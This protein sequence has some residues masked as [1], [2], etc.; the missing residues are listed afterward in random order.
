[1]EPPPSLEIFK[2]HSP[3]PASSYS[4]AGGH[5]SQFKLTEKDEEKGMCPIPYCDR[6]FKD[7]KA[8]MLTHQNKY[9]EKCPIATCNYHVEGFTRK[10]DKIR[11]ALTHYK[12]TMVCS[13]CPGSGSASDKSF[14]RTDV[15]KHHLAFVHGVAL[16]TRGKNAMSRKSR[17]AGQNTAAGSCSICSVTFANAQEFYEHLDG[18]VFRIV[19][20]M[21][22]LEDV[23]HQY[24]S[25]VADEQQVLNT[26]NG[27][28]PPL[29][30][31]YEFKVPMPLSDGDG[32]AYNT[33]PNVETMK[34]AKALYGATRDERGLSQLDDIYSLDG[35]HSPQPRSTSQNAQGINQ[36]G[37]GRVLSDVQQTYSLEDMSH[38]TPLFVSKVQEVMDNS[39]LLGLTTS[40]DPYATDSDASTELS[41]T[42]AST[43]EEDYLSKPGL[44]RRSRSRRIMTKSLGIYFR[45]TPVFRLDSL[46]ERPS[47]YQEMDTDQRSN[48]SKCSSNTLGG[49]R[50]VK[51][52][53]SSPQK[54]K[55]KKDDDQ[56]GDEEGDDQKRKKRKGIE[57]M[58]IVDRAQARPQFMACPYFKRNPRKYRHQ[59][60]CPGPGWV[61]VHRL[62]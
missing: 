51:G 50:T 35:S 27:H 9:P 62:K 32:K 17:S 53:S 11:H 56:N 5:I 43:D 36:N 6:I 30:S 60:G 23:D 52:S 19:E 2:Q 39:S 7:L 21:K 22:T 41:F 37:E 54:L 25:S 15:F 4:S 49:A 18:C 28:Y 42:S 40:A 57:E 14:N 20:Q 55:R 38:K 26:L 29:N 8:H 13:F 34:R 61:D 46:Q 48:E 31:N 10:D 3:S 33:D 44:S 58:P 24:L 1:M 45:S 16:T 47:R 12:G 59:K